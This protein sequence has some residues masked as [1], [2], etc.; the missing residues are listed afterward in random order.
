[1]LRIVHQSENV[2]AAFAE[3]E[4][5]HTVKVLRRIWRTNCVF[6]NLAGPKTEEFASGQPTESSRASRVR[7]LGME[8]LKQRSALHFRPVG[9]R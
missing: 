3:P 1:M 7:A 8:L 5:L 2:S 4:M 6:I 9:R